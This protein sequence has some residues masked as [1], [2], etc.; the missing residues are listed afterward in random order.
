MRK[1]AIVLGLLLASLSAFADITYTSPQTT[2]QVLAQNAACTGST[3]IFLITN[4][5][6]LGS[7]VGQTQHYLTISS[8]TGAKQ[9]FA[10]IQGVDVLGNTTSISNPIMGVGTVRGSGYYPKIQVAVFCTGV[11]ATFTATYSG[12]SSTYDSSVGSYLLADVDKV[13]FNAQSL[14][15][16]QSITFQTPYSS[17]AGQLFFL[18]STAI[19]GGILTVQCAT[20]GAASPVFTITPVNTTAL[21]IFTVPGFNCPQTAISFNPN[22]GGTAVIYVEYLYST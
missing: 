14:V 10:I 4:P 18:Y 15:T 12:T 16:T 9:F 11:G 20:P 1:L 17:S 3:Q 5:A 22:G 8:I 13:V 6:V 19:S 2:Q 21:Q 7:N